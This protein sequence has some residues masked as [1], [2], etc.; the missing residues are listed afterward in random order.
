M[1]S[2]LICKMI[3]S[4]FGIAAFWC[5]MGCNHLFYHP[6]AL[7]FTNPEEQG[8]AYTKHRIA[9]TDVSEL[10]A[11]WLHPDIAS[12]K[13][14]LIIQ[15]HGNAENMSSHFLFL[16]W[17]VP[18]GFDLL[19]FDYRGYGS[20]SAIAPT[21]KGLIEDTLSVL[22]WAQAQEALASY[23][24]FV[25]AQ[26]LGGAVLFPALTRLE[27][28]HRIKGVVIDSSFGSYR[29][30][31]RHKLAQMWLTWPLQYPLSYLVSDF[32]LPQE[33]AQSLQIP[34]LFFHSPRD[35]VVP[36]ASG[37]E[38]F[39]GLKSEQ[40]T[41]VDVDIPGHTT[42]F[43]HEESRFRKVLLDFLSQYGTRP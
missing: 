19:A 34:A 37:R 7:T 30:V 10:S 25:V 12:S 4:S 23:D 16:S 2:S 40:K 28:K 17:L 39:E 11:W 38:L 36:Y 27:E 14:T 3:K 9:S 18:E 43:P 24:I 5:L 15:L 20:S 35:P 41:F 8:I 26:S 22:K 1:L 21:Q 6:S 13:K 29:G 32:E 31:V 33:A 42:A